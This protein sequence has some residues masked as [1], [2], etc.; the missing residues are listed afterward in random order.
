MENLILNFFKNASVASL[1][2]IVTSIVVIL[3]CFY[4]E[5]VSYRS[6]HKDFKSTI[7]SIGILGTFIGILIGLWGFDSANISSSVPKLLD[8]LKTAFITSVVGMFFAVVLSLIQKQKGGTEAEDEIEILSSIDM[9]LW[10]LKEINKNTQI[11][12]LI[13]TKLDSIETNIRVLSK[14]ISSVK[15]ELNNNQEKLLEFLKDKLA[16]IDSSLKEA[17]QTLSEG[18]TEEIIKALEKVIQDFN[19]NLTEQFGDNFKQLN[20][21]VLNMIEWQSTYKDSIQ[22]FEKQLEKTFEQVEK[23]VSITQTNVEQISNMTEQYEAI[24]QISKNLEEVISTNQNQIQNLERHLK[25]VAEIGNSAK[26]ITEHLQAFSTTVQGSLSN[27]AEALAKLTTE[28]EKQLPQSL[29]TLNKSL[30]SLTKQFASDYEVFL[31]Q[32]SKLM[33]RNN[34]N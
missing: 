14:D 11:L 3:W 18:A 21:A 34:I 6:T 4:K 33:Q 9:K 19:N 8:G 17:V 31:E 27:Q 22:E 10:G 7:V 32:V 12:P 15:L 13:N 24:A 2:V 28:I 20:E 16:A 30:T 1:S 29:D 25:S 26:S 23:A 5:C